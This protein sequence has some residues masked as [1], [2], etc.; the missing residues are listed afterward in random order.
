MVVKLFL[1]YI[2]HFI[3]LWI[4]PNEKFVIRRSIRK[5][6][7]WIWI[8]SNPHPIRKHMDWIWIEFNQSVDWIELKIHNPQ[9]HGL[10][11][12]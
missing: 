12:D 1:Y 2:F 5:M 8:E 7:N 3:S 10:D 9:N 6:M 4:G 11:M